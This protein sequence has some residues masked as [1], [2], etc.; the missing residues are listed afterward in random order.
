MTAMTEGGWT[1]QTVKLDAT[2]LLFSALVL[3][4]GH[5]AA[6]IIDVYPSQEALVIIDEDGFPVDFHAVAGAGDS[7][8]G[9]HVR[10]LTTFDLSFLPPGAVVS[11]AVVHTRVDAIYG[12][13]TS[14]G[15]LMAARV[16]ETSGQPSIDIQ[17]TWGMLTEFIA[18][19]PF[20]G[21]IARGSR[22]MQAGWPTP[23]VMRSSFCR[24]HRQPTA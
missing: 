23:P 15:P 17:A 2:V 18:P 22:S 21:A 16:A 8:D 5:A 14:L 6:E 4:V 13:P 12:N 19:V 20:T 3:T 7:I 1:M 9:R 10:A 11:S 24:E